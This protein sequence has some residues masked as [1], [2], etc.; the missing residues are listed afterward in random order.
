LA[1][2]RK[3]PVQIQLKFQLHR[4]GVTAMSEVSFSFANKDKDTALPRIN[5]VERAGFSVNSLQQTNEEIATAKCV[6]AFWSAAAATSR[7]VQATMQ[8]ILNA[9]PS[10]RL[11]PVTI[12]EEP[13]R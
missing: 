13:Y 11:V 8:H 7:F 12:D 10:N 5:F 1:F 6:V 3:N 9:W 4:G 2:I